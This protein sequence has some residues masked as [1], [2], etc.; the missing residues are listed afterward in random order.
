MSTNSR[1]T[2]LENTAKQQQQKE[3]CAC[4]HWIAC[5]GCKAVVIKSSTIWHP[6]SVWDF[7]SYPYAYCEDCM[8]EYKPQEAA[9]YWAK[10]CTK[11]AAPKV[12]KAARS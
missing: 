2:V 1:L 11:E 4:K 8:D 10:R 5:D 3:E 7:N 6:G 12:I 9:V